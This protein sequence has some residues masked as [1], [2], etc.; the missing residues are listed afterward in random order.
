MSSIEYVQIAD[1]VGVPDTW[2]PRL[3]ATGEPFPYIDISSIDPAQKSIRGVVRVLPEEAPSRARQLVRANDVLVSTVRP[4]LNAVAIVPG[5]LDG[6]TASTGF[7]VLRPNLKYIEARYLFHWVQ[8]QEFVRY[9]ASRA[10]GASYPAVTERVVRES[11]LPLPSLGEQCRIVG[12]LDKADSIHQQRRESLRLLD[13]FLRSGYASIVGPENPRY[14]QW[15]ELTIADLAERGDGAMRTGPFGSALRHAEFTNQGDVAVLGIDNVVENRFRWAEPRFITNERY[16]KYFKRYAVRAGDVLVSI[17]GTTGKSAVVPDDVPL[18]I[19]TK[20]LATITLDRKRAHQEYVS[21]AIHMDP[22]VLAQ[23]CSANRGAIMSGLNLGLI[24]R[25][26]VRLP[27]MS[28]QLAFVRLVEATR[29]LA[30]RIAESLRMHERLKPSLMQ[31]AF[32]GDL[33]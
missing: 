29:S 24:R 8:A 16:E 14:S 1:V 2:N 30:T 31:R 15:P 22:S 7:S 23:I 32:N 11:R 26:R 25:L 12:I 10:T 4:N 9:L 21:H 17:M 3:M 27:P 13:Q 20:H 33:S 19:S 6:A 18:A 5:P 28:Q